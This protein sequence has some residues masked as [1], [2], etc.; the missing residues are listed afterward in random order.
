MAFLTLIYRWLQ[1][2]QAA[3]AMYVGWKVTSVSFSFQRLCQWLFSNKNACPA[4]RVHGWL[5]SLIKP[6]HLGCSYLTCK[7]FHQQWEQWVL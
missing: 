7:G 2:K 3:V 6:L 1:V 4:Y 5:N